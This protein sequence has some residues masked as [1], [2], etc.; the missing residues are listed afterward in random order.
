MTS[1]TLSIYGCAEKKVRRTFEVHRTS[2]KYIKSIYPNFFKNQYSLIFVQKYK[3]V[4]SGTINKNFLELTA[5]GMR[6]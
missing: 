1:S 3:N 2:Y 6:I 4:K 5:K